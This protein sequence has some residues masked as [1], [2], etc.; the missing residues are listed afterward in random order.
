MAQQNRYPESNRGREPS[1]FERQG[2]QGEADEG[3]YYPDR[4]FRGGR[5]DAP[6]DQNRYSQGGYAEEFGRARGGERFSPG[7]R[8]QPDDG[9][10][11]SAGGRN[12]ANTG[13]RSEDY[14]NDENARFP[15]GDE[16]G[17]RAGASRM[18]GQGSDHANQRYRGADNTRFPRG[19]EGGLHNGPSR[20]YGFENDRLF[21]S[22]REGGSGRNDYGAYGGYSPPEYDSSGRSGLSGGY[23]QA[24]PSHQG[25]GPKGYTRSDERLKELVCE[26][27]TEHPEIDA[28]EITVQ[29]SN[30]EVTLT[31]S[32]DSRR[33][34]FL[35]EE[36]AEHSGAKEIHNQLRLSKQS[37]AGGSSGA[38]QSTSQT[39]TNSAT[40]PAASGSSPYGSGATESKSRKNS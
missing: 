2:E 33:T 23:Q 16:G 20:S 13:Y 34:K 35:A 25:R 11:R 27:L 22:P 3:R 37:A 28:S 1:S 17:L 26:R 9:S 39:T 30:Q 19:E 14:R 36:V 38:E 10:E 5:G 32:V 12:Y 7:G 18:Y 6:A 31:G 8:S 21:G 40:S 15:R 29:V 4:D 24:R